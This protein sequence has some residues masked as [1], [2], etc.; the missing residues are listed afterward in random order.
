MSIDADE[1]SVNDETRDGGHYDR[2]TAGF[3]VTVNLSSCLSDAADQ[4]LS[5]G[6]KG[7]S[8][9]ATNSQ[10]DQRCQRI[11]CF[12]LIEQG[13]RHQPKH[14]WGFRRRASQRLDP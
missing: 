1:L 7:A 5:D 12:G 10:V 14:G 11:D 2:N 3:A 13:R 9:T 6:S 4:P 8:E